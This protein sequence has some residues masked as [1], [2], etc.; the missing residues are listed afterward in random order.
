MLSRKGSFVL[1]TFVDIDEGCPSRIWGIAHAD[2]LNNSMSIWLRIHCQSYVLSGDNR[3]PGS[4]EMGGRKTNTQ[5]D[6]LK[7]SRLDER[8]WRQQNG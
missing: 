7:S 4:W 6:L 8:S 1:V 3:G 5:A 2:F